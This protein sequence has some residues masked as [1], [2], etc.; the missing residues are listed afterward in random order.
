MLMG[1]E[2]APLGTTADSCENPTLLTMVAVVPLNFTTGVPALRLAPLIVITAPIG[3]D[4][5]LKLNT[6]GWIIKLLLVRKDPAGASTRRT[7]VRAFEGTFTRMVWLV[8]TVKFVAKMLPN[9]TAVV[10]RKF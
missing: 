5:G 3:P 1:P 4:G 9:R 6:V 8:K 2:L 7:P 10:P